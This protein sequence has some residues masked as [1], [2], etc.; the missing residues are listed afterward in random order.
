MITALE[1]TFTGEIA[2]DFGGPRREFLGVVM[3]EI[4]GKLFSEQ[5]EGCVIFKD[6]AA[7][8]KRHYFGASLF[9]VT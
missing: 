4:R 9:F 1:V 5:Q 7:S 2:Q 6:L 8:E 3:Q